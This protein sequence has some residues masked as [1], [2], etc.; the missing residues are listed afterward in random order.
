LKIDAAVMPGVAIIA[1]GAWYDP[2]ASGLDRQGNPNVLTMDIGSSQLTQGPSALS[3]LIEVARWDG[4]LPD[5][6]SPPAPAG[7]VA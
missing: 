6:P 3:A 7:V 2:D 5:S 1:T 4:A